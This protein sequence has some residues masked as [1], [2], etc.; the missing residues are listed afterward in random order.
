MGVVLIMVV[1]LVTAAAFWSRG[2]R[3]RICD[4]KN[5]ERD[6]APH[7]QIWANGFGGSETGKTGG[8]SSRTVQYRVQY[9][10]VERMKLEICLIYLYESAG[11]F[12]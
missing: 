10:R 4:R 6:L 2:T 1:R 7:F 12:T 9:S 5:V 11:D 8:R 3:K